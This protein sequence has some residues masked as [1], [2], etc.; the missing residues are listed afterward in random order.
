M[1]VGAAALDP[2]VSIPSGAQESDCL[3]WHKL[4]PVSG[5]AMELTWLKSVEIQPIEC[6]KC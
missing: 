4:L 2:T 1:I 5:D 6:R 3:H